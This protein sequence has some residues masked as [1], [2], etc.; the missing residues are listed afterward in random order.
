MSGVVKITTNTLINKRRDGQVASIVAN[1]NLSGGGGGGG[2]P[3]DVLAALRDIFEVVNPGGENVYLHIKMPVV[4]DGSISATVLKIGDYT[5]EI[6]STRLV[7][8]NLT[9][10]IF[11][12]TSAGYLT[13][14]DD[15]EIKKTTP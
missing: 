15:Q 9:T 1:N 5:I 4:I 11:S 14:K 12:L 10:V 13:T 7:I 8:K 6:D 3:I 2:A